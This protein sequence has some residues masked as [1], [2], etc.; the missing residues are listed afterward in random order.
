MGL[1]AGLKPSYRAPSDIVRS[2]LQTLTNFIFTVMAPLFLVYYVHITYDS[3]ETPPLLDSRKQRMSGGWQ[4]RKGVGLVDVHNLDNDGNEIPG[5]DVD[6]N[7]IDPGVPGIVVL[8]ITFTT[9]IPF[10]KDDSFNEL[11]ALIV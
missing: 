10:I 2:N 6:G 9:E 11:V 8:A 4:Q 3:L 7:K 1:W 5:V